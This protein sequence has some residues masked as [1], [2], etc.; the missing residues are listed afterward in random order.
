MT[1]YATLFG[2]GLFNESNPVYRGY[3]DRFADFVKKNKIDVVVLCGGH[4]DVSVPDRSEAGTISKYLKPLIPG[5]RVLV[6]D[7]SITAEQN[8]KMAREHID[9]SDKNRVFVIADS[10]RF[11]KTFWLVLDR[12]FGMGK[13]QI[14]DVCLDI[15]TRMYK[16][17]DMKSGKAMELDDIKDLLEYKNIKIVVDDKYH[18]DFTSAVH[19]LISQVFE[20]ESLYDQ[21][22]YD[23][24]LE[25]T[26]AKFKMR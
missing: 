23:R 16:N 24:Y 5:V 1:R 26:R 8:V 19:T 21:H 3:V 25:M 15:L 6:E 14:S 22:V 4:T 12:W 17:P 11:F 2:F 20:I 18:N 13:D 7:R 9:L 10:V